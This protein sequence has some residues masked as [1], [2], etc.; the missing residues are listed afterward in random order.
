MDWEKGAKGP[1]YRT[2]AANTEI[3][4]RQLGILLHEMIRRGLKTKD[5]HLVGFSLGAHVAGCAS[6]YLK[7]NGYLIGR[8]TGL[9]AASPLFRKSTFKEKYKKLDKEDAHFVDVLHTDSSPV[10]TRSTLLKCI[11]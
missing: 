7:N 2:A 9:D 3:A 10:S 6:E 8:I 11:S 4:G 1:N 5:I